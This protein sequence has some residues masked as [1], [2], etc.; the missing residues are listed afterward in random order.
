MPYEGVIAALSVGGLALGFAARDAVSNFIGAGI[1][2]ADRPF[3]KGDLIEANG[4]MGV[5]EEVGLRST[6]L[7]TVDVLVVVPNSKISDQQV[8][9]WGLRW[10]RQ[11]VMTLGAT[12]DTPRIKLDAFVKALKELFESQATGMPG[13]AVALDNFG[14]SSI[15]IKLVGSFDTV[16]GGDFRTAK[17]K[18]MGDIIDLAGD[19][20]VE[21]AFPTQTVHVAPSGQAASVYEEQ[22]T[23]AA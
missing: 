11:V 14:S 1:L 12:C 16:D 17:H 9:N 5:V 8:N 4:Q 20:G 23:T 3:A 7:R 21:F 6:R 18:L 19:M 10:S 15:D 13:A 22:R 2:M